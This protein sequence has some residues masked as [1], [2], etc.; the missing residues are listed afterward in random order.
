MEYESP[1]QDIVDEP[2]TFT[3]EVKLSA[4]LLVDAVQ[5]E[6]HLRL[7]AQSHSHV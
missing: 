7:G 2:I 5:R 6:C 4:V 3:V 1:M